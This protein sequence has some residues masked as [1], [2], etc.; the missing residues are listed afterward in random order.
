MTEQ[1]PTGWPTPLS[2]SAQVLL[3]LD[4]PREPGTDP[5]AHDVSAAARIGDTLFVAGDECAYVEALYRRADGAFG[6]HRRVALSEHFD[7]PESDDEMDVEGLS[8]DEDQW[9]WIVGSHS[10]TRKKPKKS[11]PVDAHAIAR[12][13]R[14]KDNH[15]R[16]FVGRL[17]LVRENGDRWTVDPD[18]AEMLPVGKHD[19]KLLRELEADPLFA[20]FLSLPAKENGLDVEGLVSAD[21]RVWLGC[22]GPVINAWACALEF[23]VHGDG[24]GK[25]K[26]DGDV[27]KRWLDLGGLGI[28]DLKRRGEDVLILA[29]PT[30][31]ISGPVRLYR[32]RN[33]R[34]PPADDALLERPEPLGWLPFGAGVDHPEA[35]APSD[36]GLIV[37]CDSPSRARLTPEGIL[38]DVFRYEALGL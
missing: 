8:I 9:L 11:K 5:V 13:A 23:D 4:D 12:M 18:S 34:E 30:M 2:P 15:N 25:L 7:M 33:W 16:M 21:G 37:V 38:A 22:R 32:W 14:L 10:L 35:L 6:D 24:H 29:G 27:R 1:T 31:A 20:P 19:N 26:I 3:D 17:K 36:D 28:R